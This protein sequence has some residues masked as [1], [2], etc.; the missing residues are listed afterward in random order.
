MALRQAPNEAAPMID[1]VDRPDP[2]ESP[3]AD[4]PVKKRGGGPRTAEGKEQSKRNAL[5]HGM[6][7]ETHA[8]PNEDPAAIAARADFWNDAAF[9]ILSGA[10][11]NLRIRCE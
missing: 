8:M 3:S 5:K 7:A 6:R 1:D 2:H 10:L 4:A 9:P 11:S